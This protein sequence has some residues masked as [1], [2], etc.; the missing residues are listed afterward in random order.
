MKYRS[1]E[2]RVGATV[3]IAALILIVG[4]M[5][6]EGFKSGKSGYLIKANFPMVGGIH[7]G[8]VVNVNGVE[9]GKVEGVVLGKKSVVVNMSIDVGTVIPEDSKVVLQS[10]G[11][12]GERVILIIKGSSEKAVQDGMK[13]EGVYEP[14]ISETFASLADV[15]GDLKDI[16]KDMGRITKVLTEEGKFKKSVENLVV[17]TDEL[18][19]LISETAPDF[20][21]GTAEFKDSAVRIGALIEKNSDEIERVIAGLDTTVGKMPVVIG[22]IDTLTA[23][24]IDI[25]KRLQT[26]DSTLGVLLNDREFLDSLQRT[27]VELEKLVVDIKKHPK[28]YLKVEIF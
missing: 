2:L 10:K 19:D 5:W 13:L 28:K 18:R 21:K 26:R 8:D 15:L 20:K 6:F 22:R 24:F 27:V 12:L 16:A 25:S 17:I 3:V 9:R 11:L 1:L 23:L 14:G 4:L 7:R